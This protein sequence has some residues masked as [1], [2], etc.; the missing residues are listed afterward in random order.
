MKQ[1]S[2]N[3]EVFIG[4]NTEIELGICLNAIWKFSFSSSETLTFP[5][6]PNWEN[7]N[8]LSCGLTSSISFSKKMTKLIN[9]RK[10]HS[11]SE[12]GKIENHRK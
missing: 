1:S 11:A 12:T 8:L 2:I 9:G 7:G 4:A 5:F 10:N 6:S 3:R